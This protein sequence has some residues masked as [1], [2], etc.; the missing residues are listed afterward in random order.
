VSQGRQILA[1]FLQFIIEINVNRNGKLAPTNHRTA[2]PAMR[3]S[4]Y[5]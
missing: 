2:P 3:P 4:R 5:Q 1:A